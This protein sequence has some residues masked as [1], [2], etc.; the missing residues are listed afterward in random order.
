MST[1]AQSP[2]SQIVETFWSRVVPQYKALVERAVRRRFRL[3]DALRIKRAV[4]TLVDLG[5]DVFRAV[6]EEMGIEAQETG[7]THALQLM[8]TGLGPGM[9]QEAEKPKSD[10]LGTSE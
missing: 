7:Q 5:P 9:G 10:T 6:V 3:W 4:D 1:D 2:W 8:M